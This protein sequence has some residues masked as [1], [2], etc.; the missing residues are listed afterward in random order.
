MK[1]EVG[2]WNLSNLVGRGDHRSD[3]KQIQ[4]IFP[5]L[6]VADITT[7]PASF[8]KMISFPKKCKKSTEVYDSDLLLEEFGNK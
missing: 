5:F 4:K 3:Q 8:K 1:R 6:V 2:G 7:H